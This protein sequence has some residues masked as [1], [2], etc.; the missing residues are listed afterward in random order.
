MILLHSIFQTSEDEEESQWVEKV[1][2][3]RETDDSVA[4]ISVKGPR[5]EVRYEN[6][7]EF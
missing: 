1:G 4:H 3:K 7:N 6:S 5:L 2:K